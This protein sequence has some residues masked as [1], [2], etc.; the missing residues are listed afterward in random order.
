MRSN[1]SRKAYFPSMIKLQG[2]LRVSLGGCGMLAYRQTHNENGK[3]RQ[4]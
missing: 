3:G 2:S 1:F 4:T